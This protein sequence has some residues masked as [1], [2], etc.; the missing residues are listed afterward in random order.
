MK[1]GLLS[2]FV[3]LAVLSAPGPMAKADAQVENFTKA[4]RAVPAPEIPEQAATLVTQSPDAE[5]ASAALSILAAALELSP[6]TAPEVV[7]AIARKAPAVAPA[8]AAAASEK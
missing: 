6:G 5:R 8:L 1:C 2:Y 4:L 7:G 3:A